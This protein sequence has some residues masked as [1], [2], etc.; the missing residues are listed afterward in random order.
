MAC[1]IPAYNHAAYVREAIL[2]AIGPDVEIVAVDDAS[3][4][5]TYDVMRPLA[6]PGVTILRND[7]NLGGV[8]TCLRALA[9]TTAPY[10]TVLASDDRWLP[11]RVQRQLTAMRDAEWSFGRAYV[12]DAA[13]VRATGGAQGPPPDSDGMLRTLLRGQAIYAPTL[14]FRRD[15][16]ERAGGVQDALW[17]DLALT[18][19]FAALAEPVYVAK[20]LVEYRVHGANVHLDLLD[21]GLHIDAHRQ[22]VESLAAWP[23]LPER[24]RPVVAEHLAVWQA[25]AGLRD[26]TLPDR[27]VPKRALD[28]VVRR[29]AR[30]LVREV[31]GALLR[32]F[33]VALRLR[34]LHDAARA[35]A[36][37]RGGP[38]WRRALRSAGRRARQASRVR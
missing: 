4:D 1:L 32:R 10:V 31:D 16:L 6:G 27:T 11:G 5:G 21:R 20:P 35:I 12:I 19:R 24:H 13:G 22:A 25:L 17:E 30:D 15:L 8:G 34:G 26:G 37:V 38:I 7:T 28:G 23:D 3:A 9:A 2:S 36:D 29:Q 33:E 14:L 18:L